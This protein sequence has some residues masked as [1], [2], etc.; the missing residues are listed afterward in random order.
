MSSSHRVALQAAVQ[1]AIPA[2]VPQ[3]A[4][5]GPSDARGQMRYLHH[6]VAGVSNPVS[7]EMYR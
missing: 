7:K 4:L 2:P 6:R 5:A 3:L 1:P